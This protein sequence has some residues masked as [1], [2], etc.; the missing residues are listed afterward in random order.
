MVIKMFDS[1][2]NDLR[3]TYNPNLQEISE[4]TERKYDKSNYFYRKEEI[5]K[6]SKSEFTDFL[7]ND[8][9]GEIIQL[10]DDEGVNYLKQYNDIEG[11]IAYILSWSKYANEIFYNKSFL[12][13]FLSTDISYYYAS[14]SV[15]NNEVCDL[16]VNRCLSLNKDINYIGTLISYF[17]AEYNLMF[18]DRF[19]SPNDLI[20]ELFKKNTQ[21]LGRKILEKYN[22]I[23]RAHV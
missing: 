10:F 13:L 15:L 11:R 7:R 6:S 9:T 5:I 12:D 23:G 4:S 19:K 16:I 21:A 1:K 22:K 3:N 8:T 20:Y 17:G 14:L 18:I 2:K